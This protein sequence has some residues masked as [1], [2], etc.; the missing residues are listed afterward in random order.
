VTDQ[1]AWAPI[2]NEHSLDVVSPRVRN[3]QAHPYW[4]LIADQLWLR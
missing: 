1:A 4:G 2:V 3:Y